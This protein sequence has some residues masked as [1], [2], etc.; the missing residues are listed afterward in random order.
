MGACLSTGRLA[1]QPA[2]AQEPDTGVARQLYEQVVAPASGLH[3]A[4]S[5]ARCPGG[6]AAGG[7][8][9]AVLV[10]STPGHVF[11]AL[12]EGLGEHGAAVAAFCRSACWGAYQECAVRHPG[13]PLQ[14][15]CST[16]ERLD[17]AIF[18]TDRLQHAVGAA[19]TGTSP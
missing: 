2:T 4:V 7:G 8:G 6:G 15:L 12:F 1:A 18:A 17:S 9:D 10:K 3:V 16:L 19:R 5:S 11:V 13:E 14:Q